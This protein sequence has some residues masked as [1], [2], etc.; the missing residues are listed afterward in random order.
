MYPNPIPSRI[1]IPNAAGRINMRMSIDMETVGRNTYWYVW[2]HEAT[3]KVL[4][5]TEPIQF[6]PKSK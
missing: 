3:G 5:S 2:I 4:S 1:K 6:Y